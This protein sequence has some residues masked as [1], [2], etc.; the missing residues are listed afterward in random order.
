MAGSEQKSFDTPDEVREFPHG[1]AEIVNI[2]GGEVG[3][4]ILEPGWRWSEHIKPIAGTELCEAPHFQYVLS[5]RSASAW[6]TAPSSRSGPG[7]GGPGARPRRLGHR[8][9][10][11]GRHRLGRR[12]RV[13]EARWAQRPSAAGAPS[14]TRPPLAFRYGLGAESPSSGEVRPER[15]PTYPRAFDHPGSPN[16]P[17]ARP[18]R[19]T[20][21]LALGC[22]AAAA[23]AVPAQGIAADWTPPRDVFPG[24][25]GPERASDRVRR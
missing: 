1:R 11:R 9:R 10:D 16:M 20:L 12:P 4:L 18:R 15:E 5:G 24:G 19:R 13:G 6:L 21:R 22:A 7:G 2:G 14:R 25:A 8:R 17:S 23:L 3:R